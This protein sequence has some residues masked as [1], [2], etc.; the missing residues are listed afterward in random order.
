MHA[1]NG[2][3]PVITRKDY[4]MRYCVQENLI[5]RETNAAEK[6]AHFCL[7]RV[8]VYHSFK[9]KIDKQINNES[10]LLLLLLLKK[11]KKK[12]G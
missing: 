3:L 7:Y 10:T 5:R 6:G 12:K 4:A 2:R 11:E 1:Y 8:K 9:T